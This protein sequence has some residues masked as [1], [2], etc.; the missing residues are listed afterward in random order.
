MDEMIDDCG[1][2]EDRVREL[3]GQLATTAAWRDAA[4]AARDEAGLSATRRRAH[5]ARRI[6]GSTANAATVT[7]TGT[8]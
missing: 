7:G 8:T 4:L 3:E 2:L 6:C 5:L 1:R